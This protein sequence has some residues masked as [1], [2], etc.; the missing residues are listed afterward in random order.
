MGGISGHIAHPYEKYSELE[1]FFKNLVSNKY[2]VTEKVDGNNIYFGLNDLGQVVFARNLTEEPW[3][4]PRTKFGPEHPAHQSFTIG[5]T[6]IKKSIEKLSTSD[7]IKFLLLN[8]DT[9]PGLFI[10]AEILFGERPNL[11]KY[12]DKGTNFI[13]FH[14]FH[15]RK[16]NRYKKLPENSELLGTLA[17]VLSSIKISVPVQKISGSDLRDLSTS[18]IEESSTWKFFGPLFHTLPKIRLGDFWSGT[19]REITE[20][21]GTHLLGSMTS[22]LAQADDFNSTEDQR[23]EGLVVSTPEGQVKITGGFRNLGDTHWKPLRSDLPELL[24]DLNDFER[25]LFGIKTSNKR[26]SEKDLDDRLLTPEEKSALGQKVRE[27]RVALQALFDS[28]K[29]S[30][31]PKKDSILNTYRIVG[32]KLN[33]LLD[34]N[35]LKE[36]I[37]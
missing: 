31:N 28:V 3:S 32:I 10:N 24:Q 8:K 37:V 11:I 9:T 16:E 19:P 23:L 5:C 36:V 15:A 35:N 21:I 17:K 33:R 1:D 13:V 6:A 14:S 12:T 30:D 22:K 34:T 18:T 7:K 20:K 29:T 4:D 25:E 27:V 2:P 26:I